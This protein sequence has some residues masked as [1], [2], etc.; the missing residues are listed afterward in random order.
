MGTILAKHYN[1]GMVQE[2]IQM[3]R[4]TH[5]TNG[6]HKRQW[7]LYLLNIIMKVWSKRQC[8]WRVMAVESQRAIGTILAKHYNEGIVEEIMQ[9]ARDGCSG[10]QMAMGTI[11][12][13]HYNEGMVE[14]TM[15]KSRKGSWGAQNAMGTI[16]EIRSKQQIDNDMRAREARSD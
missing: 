8:E 15:Q 13:K 3:A 6:E 1:E 12:A 11:L 5:Y 14:E 7:A 16:I 4:Y 10:A 2:I 9:I